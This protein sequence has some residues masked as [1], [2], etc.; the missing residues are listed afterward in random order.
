M[1]ENSDKKDE[2]PD[3]SKWEGYEG[4]WPDFYIPIPEEEEDYTELGE[5]IAAELL[6]RVQER[7]REQQ[8]QREQQGK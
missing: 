6:P 7:M 1:S 2:T 5:Q 8:R 3:V 4:K